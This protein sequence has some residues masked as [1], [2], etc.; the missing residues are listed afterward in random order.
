MPVTEIGYEA[1]KDVK[2]INV[3]LPESITSIGNGAFQNVTGISSLTLPSNLVSIGSRAFADSDIT[4]ETIP[5]TLTFI[6]HTAFE[7]C[8]GITSLYFSEGLEGIGNFAFRGCTN[9]T[10]VSIPGTL[11]SI[12]NETFSG[13][14][15]IVEA[16]VPT[17][18]LS[19]INKTALKSLAISSGE[20]IP[21]WLFQYNAV[22]ETVSIAS[23]V[24][25]VGNNAFYHCTEL[26]AVTFESGSQLTEIGGDAFEGCVLL[27]G[28]ML[29]ESLT[30]IGNEAFIGCSVLTSVNIPASVSFIGNGAFRNCSNLESVVI[31][32][33]SQLEAI[34]DN[35]FYQ[36]VALESIDFGENSKISSIGTYAFGGCT[37]LTTIS[38]PDC[39]T[40]IHNYAFDGDEKITVSPIGEGSQLQTI[41][42]YAFRGCQFPISIFPTGLTSIGSSAFAEN[43]AI[44]SLII[45]EGI[46]RVEN[47]AFA[48]CTNIL[49]IYI[50]PN[51][52]YTGD[53]FRAAENLT[54]FTGPT[55]SL[56]S[57]YRYNL[58]S[59][60]ITN[61]ST[62]AKDLTNGSIFSGC[63]KL[64]SITL[65]ANLISINGQ[66][67]RGCT[68]LR[69]V[70]FEGESQLESIVDLAFYECTSLAEIDLPDTLT[71]IGTE[72]FYS[73]GLT[74]IT[75]PAGVNYLGRSVFKNCAALESVVIGDNSQLEIIDEAMFYQCIALES[76][77]FGENSKISSIG[78]YA[79]G[80][81]TALTTI[82]IPDCVTVI[83]NYAFDGDEKITVSPIGE[84]SQLQTIGNYAFRGCQF[85]ISIFPT[86]LTSI[87]SSAFAEN[88]AI[89]SLI[90]HEGINRVENGAFAGCTN[91]LDIYIHPN[92]EYTG[93]AFRA[94]ENLTTFT[95]P[96]VSLD[97]IYRYNLV[98][99]VITNASTEA[100]DL[101]N[102]SIFSGCTKLESI[103]LPANLISINGQ[104]F[105][106]CTALREVIFEGESQLESIVDLA[107]YECTSLAEIDLPDTLT[108]IGTEAFYSSGLTSITIPAGVNY[109]GR[110]VFK[111]CAALESVV[112]GDN[113]QLEI[114]DEAM[115]YQ[116]IALESIDFGENSKISYIA[117][118]A[119]G[120][121]TSL[122]E[123][124]IP[125]SVTTMGNYVFANNSELT[126]VYIGAGSKLTSIGGWTFDGCISNPQIH[127]AGSYEEWGAKGVIGV[128][129][130]VVYNSTKK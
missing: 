44:T 46:N 97:S 10:S 53:A 25:T 112:I 61:A 121:C 74:S 36:C 107:F 28:V 113:S 12:G 99:V 24:K 73:S 22:L 17:N 71:S 98:S 123:I 47:G 130:N 109:L 76:I 100:K 72:A 42:N 34:N 69:E 122:T 43:K 104:A 60:V 89:T 120:E 128:T 55:V 67:F 14:N 81:C 7:N 68:A 64:E 8:L 79:F 103:T 102:G 116:C 26:K 82:S 54:T 129:V 65:P 66:A 18:A 111:N 88:K 86:G 49:D 4:L 45:H 85:P 2:N 41:G 11:E 124:S 35:T 118:Y 114:I 16:S 48:G 90:I 62:E 110:S 59:V 108:S 119:F 51:I 83:H 1:F 78:T 84:G 77:D 19:A 106:G 30:T 40:V 38:I 91:I 87:G 117:T 56:D 6:D 21:S 5:A 33:N 37:A 115:F 63:T 57:I 31:G 29:P 80:G 3:T 126:A 52:E 39:V 95:G 105:R 93:D 125:D 32:D 27:C 127:F 75:I 58:V 94:A 50:H 9:L 92:I 13:C 70:I 23:T 20:S 101:T 15:A 96:T